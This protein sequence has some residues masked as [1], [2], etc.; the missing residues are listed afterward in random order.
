MI[1]GALFVTSFDFRGGDN[2]GLRPLELPNPSPRF[3]A[4][5]EGFNARG[6]QEQ[7]QDSRPQPPFFRQKRGQCKEMQENARLFEFIFTNI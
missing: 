1:P 4:E 5:N 7:M 2:K 3:Y 6:M